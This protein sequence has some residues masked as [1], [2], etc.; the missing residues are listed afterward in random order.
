MSKDEHEQTDNAGA[1]ARAPAAG[2]DRADATADPTV[3]RLSMLPGLGVLAL[4]VIYTHV[5]WGPMF[6][7]HADDISMWVALAQWTFT[8]ALLGGGVVLIAM[9]HRIERIRRWAGRVSDRPASRAWLK[10]CWV[11]PPV[12]RTVLLLMAPVVATNVIYLIVV[13][14]KEGFMLDRL[15]PWVVMVCAV[16][17]E[18]AV[19][20]TGVLLIW[21]IVRSRPLAVAF[22]LVYLLLRVIDLALYHFGHTVFERRYLMYISDYSVKAWLVPEVYAVGAWLIVATAATGLVLYVR[23]RP[24]PMAMFARWVVFTVLFVLVA[25]ARLFFTVEHLYTD[26]WMGRDLHIAIWDRLVYATQNSANNMMREM[27]SGR[28]RTAHTAATVDPFAEVIRAYGLP[29]GPREYPRLGLKPFK[30]IVFLGV[31]SLSMNL[32]AAHNPLLTKNDTPHFFGAGDIL[33]I[34]FTNYR[35]TTLHTQRGLTAT[36]TSH[37]C[38]RV[39]LDWKYRNSVVHQLRGAGFRTLLVRT[40]SRFY[41]QEHILWTDAGFEQIISR[42]DFERRDDTKAF[43]TGWGVCDRIAQDEI[44]SQLK[45]HKDE[46][47]FIHWMGTDTHVPAG[48]SDFRGLEYPDDYKG[49]PG[50]AQNEHMLRAVYHADFDLRRFLNRLKEE[51]LWDDQTLVFVS[52]DHCSQLSASWQDTPGYPKDPLH[53]IPL[54]ILTPQKLPFGSDMNIRACQLDFEPTLLHL[55]DMPIP[56]GYWGTSLF[57]PNLPRTYVGWHRKTVRV[58]TADARHRINVDRPKGDLQAGFMELFYTLITTG[59]PEHKSTLP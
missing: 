4:G 25:P 14:G 54:V 55:L 15:L 41:S 39:A 35:T 38:N 50:T 33:P 47:I 31:E 49:E 10:F 11:L 32:L 57:A 48:R 1:E 59:L 26:P 29:L 8:L 37:P 45:A 56:H 21:L 16:V 42:E 51:G 3:R 34:T 46:K 12:N 23:T 30:R 24:V 2:A 9:G 44:I 53:N 6:R 40:D 58:E 52:A 5:Y 43:I 28:M 17:L 36:W 19:F 7:E 20:V 18:T 13:Q 22:A 27:L